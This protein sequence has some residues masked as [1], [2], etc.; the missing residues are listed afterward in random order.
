VFNRFRIY[1]ETLSRF[2]SAFNDIEGIERRHDR[3]DE[4]KQRM[5][6]ERSVQ[7]QI[8]RRK[9]SVSGNPTS[10]SPAIAKKTA[11]L[12]APSPDQKPFAVER[13][14]KPGF[15]CHIDGRQRRCRDYPTCQ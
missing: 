1:R 11:S 9:P 12:G 10:D 8:L 7:Q 6:L 5:R 13:R 3:K 15:D 14:A 4:A 2:R